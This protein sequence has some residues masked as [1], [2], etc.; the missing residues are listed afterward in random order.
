MKAQPII[1]AHN[2]PGSL[3]KLTEEK[4]GKDAC[5]IKDSCLIDVNFDTKRSL[6]ERATCLSEKMA[7]DYIIPDFSDRDFELWREFIQKKIGILIDPNRKD[8]LK[9][10]L[11]S[12]MMQLSIRSFGAYYQFITNENRNSNEWQALV[13]QIVNIQSSF[14][15][16]LPSFDALMEFVFPDLVRQS[17]FVYPILIWSVGSSR[18]QEAYSLSMAFS[19]TFN[20]KENL[21]YIVTGS[22]ISLNAIERARK[23][24]YSY[25]EVM[26]MPDHFKEKYM[27]SI[28]DSNGIPSNMKESEY[29]LILKH[30]IRYRVK[31]TIRSHVRFIQN[32]IMM[33]NGDH[34]LKKDIS[35][36][37]VIF[38]QNVLIY[39]SISD[40]VRVISALL[41]RL[42][43]NGYIFFAPGE[44]VGIKIMSGAIPMRFKDT[45]SFRRTKEAVH[46]QIIQ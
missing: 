42:N 34:L 21:N 39:L 1:A 2:V 13:E 32:N 45:L 7:D 30:K 36:Q 33:L 8:F 10:R 40:R 11:L 19:H 43:P 31:D 29:P 46:V 38:C 28:M 37:D 3:E 20:D 41:N 14:F 25:L 6:G 26:D 44:M 24:E 27:E 22:D 23:G 9:R 12:R 15:R 5:V 18:G 4:T 17:G 35:F 16:H